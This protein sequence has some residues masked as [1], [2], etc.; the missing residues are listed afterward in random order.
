[1]IFFSAKI[2]FIFQNEKDKIVIIIIMNFLVIKTANH[3]CIMQIYRILS[4][5]QKKI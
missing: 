5:C 3:Y 1:M 4:F 2:R